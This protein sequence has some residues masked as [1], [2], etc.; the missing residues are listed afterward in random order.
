MSGINQELLDRIIREYDSN[1]GARPKT[2][3]YSPGRINLIGE[4]TDYNKGFVLPSAVSFG[5]YF[6][7]GA[8]SD[9][10][11]KWYALDK[12]MNRC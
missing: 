10:V 5:I 12:N 8:C 2:L 3:L 4:H 6:A 11:H 9:H 7:I 1:F